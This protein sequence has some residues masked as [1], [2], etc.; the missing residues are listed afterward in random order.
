MAFNDLHK[1][2][3]ITTIETQN[4]IC[5]HL[6]VGNDL[7]SLEAARIIKNK[8]PDDKT[9]LIFK[10]EL[11]ND[12]L[13]AKGPCDIRGEVNIAKFKEL[14][15]ELLINTEFCES[16]YYKD[17]K[18][19][20]FSGRGKS[21][22]LLTGESYYTDPRVQLDHEKIFSLLDQ[23]DEM[24]SLKNILRRVSIQKIIREDKRWDIYCLN[25]EIYQTTHLYW[26]EGPSDLLTLLENKNIL[27]DQFIEFS[28]QTMSPCSLNIRIEFD[29]K[30]TDIKETIFVPL[31]YTH[32][33][34][35]FIGEF[36]VALDDGPQSAQFVH[37]L[38]K[39]NSSE[40]NISKK[41]R[42]FKKNLEKIIPKIKK[43]HFRE[44]ISLVEKSHIKE[45]NDELSLL[46]YYGQNLSV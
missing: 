43:M 29:E 46:T 26:G 3:K 37:F 33:W 1:L 6:I 19:K 22:K 20:A 35:H 8:Y 17:L 5:D 40:E 38:D 10:G 25:G 16:V 27:T 2:K 39:E 21:E 13:K 41:M 24:D 45:I 14:R 7:F 42:I 31:S 23:K 9:N 32:E 30:V 34:G 15:P 4:I 36:E 18:L 44:F 12:F 11:T 28:E